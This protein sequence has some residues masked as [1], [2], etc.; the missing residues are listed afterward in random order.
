MKN[1]LICVDMEG[2]HGV[3]GVPYQGLACELNDY[4]IAVESATKEVNTLV[5]ALY[6]GGADNVYIWD[7]HGNLDNLDFNRI[8]SRAQK[9]HP[10]SNNIDRIDFVDGLNIAAAFYIGYH[11]REGSFNGILAHTYDSSAVQYYKINGKQ[12]GEFDMDAYMAAEYDIPSVFAASDDVCLGQIKDFD[13]EIVTVVTKVGTGRNSAIFR[14]EEELLKEIYDSALIAMNKKIQVK[15]LQFPCDFEVRFT[16]MEFAK[17][18]IDF[19]VKHVPQV[20]YGEDSHTIKA[21]VN[22]IKELKYML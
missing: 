11:S 7:N 14:D 9:V 13:S 21:V 19:K 2:V 3:V 22:N 1:Y 5:K 4:A 17:E 20:V 6:D 12:V 16:R 10:K 8:D 15:K 18:M